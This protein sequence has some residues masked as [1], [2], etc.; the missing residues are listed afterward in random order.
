MLRRQWV[1]WNSFAFAVLVPEE[2]DVATQL[3][4]VWRWHKHLLALPY[5]AEAIKEKEALGS[6]A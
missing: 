5:I 1:S 6:E 3:P 4:N 2:F